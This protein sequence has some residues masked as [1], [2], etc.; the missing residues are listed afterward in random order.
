MAEIQAA[1][2]IYTNVE[3]DKSPAR[4]RGFQLWCH[5]EGLAES[6]LTEARR[7]LEN[8]KNPDAK[9]G[10]LVRHLFADLGEGHYLLSQTTPQD[11]P[12]KF[13]RKG[14]FHAHAL[15]L[16]ADEFAKIH[17]NPFPLLEVFKFDQSPEETEG[18]RRP[19]QPKFIDPIIV[20]CPDPSPTGNTLPGPFTDLLATEYLPRWVTAN[21][22]ERQPVC[23]GEKPDI[24]LGYLRELF[25]L[26]PESLRRRATFDT[27][28][29][30][31][32]VAAHYFLIANPDERLAGT[33][34]GF[35]YILLNKKGETRLKLPSRPE[36]APL[37]WFAGYWNACKTTPLTEID[38]EAALGF[39]EAIYDKPEK[40]SQA[41]VPSGRLLDLLERFP[42]VATKIASL[43]MARLKEEYPRAFQ[44]K[45]LLEVG[46]KLTAF[47]SAMKLP[48]RIRFVQCGFEDP[49]PITKLACE[50]L[51]S[52][53]AP[54]TKLDRDDVRRWIKDQQSETVERIKLMIFRWSEKSFEQCLK[55]L[56]NSGNTK[57]QQWY[58]QWC[59]STVPELQTV[60][61]GKNQMLAE[62][63]KP[64]ELS[65]DE[66]RTWRLVHQ[67]TPVI[68][69]DEETI[70]DATAADIADDADVVT[71]GVEVEST[72]GNYDDAKI[73]DD[74][75]AEIK[76]DEVNSF[77]GQE[78]IRQRTERSSWLSK[79]ATV[80]QRK[81]LSP[82]A[83]QQKSIS[84][85][86]QARQADEKES[87]PSL[88]AS[89]PQVAEY[90][91]EAW[92]SIK[93]FEAKHV[94]F[95]KNQGL[96]RP[97]RHLVGMALIPMILKGSFHAR[98]LEGLLA[99]PEARLIIMGK[100]FED[101]R[102]EW[103]MSAID[104]DSQKIMERLVRYWRR[105]DFAKFQEQLTEASDP[106]FRHFVDIEAF[107][108]L[109]GSP[110][111]ERIE[112]SDVF[113]VGW[114]ALPTDSSREI[115]TLDQFK[116][117]ASHALEPGT[118][119][120]ENLQRLPK[121]NIEKMNRFKWILI[122]LARPL[123]S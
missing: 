83:L 66:L 109:K 58:Y 78:E 76:I 113:F 108:K 87:L 110:C 39:L 43:A 77:G 102:L 120:S 74:G 8:F 86:L 68:L 46:R 94:Y 60:G 96:G 116:A 121:L 21:E 33:L 5:S 49:E 101:T 27:I 15:I 105:P 73:I 1:Q 9:L 28:S 18:K 32:A 50:V 45:G 36:D 111:H 62:L 99:I 92:F 64:A 118:W 112:D 38:R 40:V 17:F 22:K 26:L 107:T 6:V 103:P 95:I 47:V 10:P 13:G 56:S 79:S 91:A 81:S 75:G 104:L 84:V 70:P 53:A 19:D 20:D 29:Y 72:A 90:L 69:P 37:V 98:L 24:V 119:D 2:L 52:R 48:A 12:D 100:L 57:L 11:K 44:P 93:R 16:T 85:L 3:A 123:K 25:V 51:A 54:L 122:R 106:A 23:L 7:R 42:E 88:F 30:G 115:E 63:L 80:V 4:V 82:A 89:E 65:G 117:L 71:D 35:R 61:T 14:R 34:T 114:E 67:L 41:P 97:A 55:V 31:S 59:R